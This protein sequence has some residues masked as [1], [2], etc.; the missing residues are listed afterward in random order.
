MVKGAVLPHG[1]FAIVIGI[2]RYPYLRSLK[3]A[4]GDAERM[5]EWLTTDGGVPEDEAH[6]K[7]ILS[8]KT[9]AE[10]DRARPVQDEIDDAF[11]QIYESAAKLRSQGIE[12]RRLWVYFAG[13]GAS[14]D[15]LHIALLM[16]DARRGT[17]GHPGSMNSALNAPKYHSGLLN[18][19]VFSDQIFFYDCCRVYDQRITGRPP[20]W[21]ES[22][23]SPGV[24]DVAQVMVYGSSVTGYAHERPVD[25]IRMQGLFT[26]ALLEALRGHDDAV[27]EIEGQRV[28]TSDSINGYV[29]R[30]VKELAKKFDLEQR[31]SIYRGGSYRE[32]ILAYYP[33]G[34]AR[35]HQRSRHS[36][37]LRDRVHRKGEHRINPSRDC[38]Q[39]RQPSPSPDPTGPQS[40]GCSDRDSKWSSAALTPSMSAISPPV[41]TILRLRFRV[42]GQT[43]TSTSPKDRSSLWTRIDSPS[44]GTC[45]LR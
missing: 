29:A 28:V 21:E 36:M 34:G 43:S 11:E 37:D 38:P 23:P 1:D 12:P 14:K 16:A 32:L 27:K 31:I 22:E 25:L 10:T 4:V 6:L 30:R 42:I 13:H 33:P 26:K 9:A 19:A 18:H 8:D 24:V 5:I 39:E 44:I 20:R 35:R 17:P 15:D 7:R 45:R 3:G 40:F 2:D 41:P